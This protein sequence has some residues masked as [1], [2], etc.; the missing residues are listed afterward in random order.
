MSLAQGSLT[1]CQLWGG[2]HTSSKRLVKFEGFPNLKDFPRKRVHCLGW[3]HILI[4]SKVWCG[5]VEYYLYGIARISSVQIFR[6]QTSKWATEKDWK[7]WIRE[8]SNFRAEVPVVLPEDRKLSSSTGAAREI[9]RELLAV[10]VLS[11]WFDHF[12]AGMCASQSCEGRTLGWRPCRQIN[13]LRPKKV[14]PTV[15]ERSPS[16]QPEYL[17]ARASNLLFPGSVG[18]VLC[19]F[20]MDLIST[21]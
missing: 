19:K 20:L 3:C 7:A 5:V 8:I 18:L 15:H 4:P 2:N 21:C 16:L 1:Y 6:L 17:R 12:G 11:K 14:E 9:F 13:V 10:A